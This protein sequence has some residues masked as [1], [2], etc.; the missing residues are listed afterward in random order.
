PARQVTTTTAVARSASKPPRTA[1]PI[2]ASQELVSL[3]QPHE[4]RNKPGSGS[5][6]LGVVPART[7][8]TEERTVLPVLAHTHRWLK[9]RLPG[10]PNSHAGWIKRTASHLWATDWRIA[11][12]LSRRKVVV[13]RASKPVRTFMAVIGKPSTPTPTGHFFVEESLAL[14]P[15]DLGAPFALALSARSDVFQ[16]FAGG[17]GQIAIHG[18]NNIGGVLGTAVSHGCVR[19]SG[20]AMRWLVYHVKPGV[21]VTIT[22]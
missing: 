14:G 5:K 16:E 13:Y 15:T 21:P 6:S 3:L 4:A 20:E 12:D 1:A 8:I 18:V 9:V 11:L 2:A 22:S 19:L 17:P 7:P 10:R